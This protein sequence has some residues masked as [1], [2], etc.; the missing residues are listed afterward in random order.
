MIVKMKKYTVLLHKSLR[1]SFLERLQELG[2]MDVTVAD[3]E[4]DDA[5]RELLSQIERRRRAAERF[6]EMKLSPEELAL[7][8]PYA[9][10]REA[11][12]AYAHASSEIDSIE[13]SLA[14]LDKEMDE[15]KL[16][17][18]IPIDQMNALLARGVQIYFYS[19]SSSEFK[20]KYDQWAEQYALEEISDVNGTTCFVIF[21]TEE[22]EPQIDA[23]Q[24]KRPTATLQQREQ[25][26]EKLSAQLEEWQKVVVRAA[27]SAK[28]IE[29]DAD[30]LKDRLQ[31]SQVASTSGSEIEGHVVVLRG[32]APVD[33][34]AAVDAMLD[35]SPETIYIKE[36]PAPD[37]ETP[38]L[39]RNNRFAR[40]FELI[41]SFYSL[42]KYG[43]M[44]L[45]PYFAPFY[46]IFFGFCMGDAGYGVL[47][48]LIGLF[49]KWKKGNGMLGGVSTLTILLGISTIIFGLLTGS[50]F[51]IQLANFALLEPY[52]EKFLNTNNLF[53]LAFALGIVQILFG[54]TLNVINTTR[55]QGFIYS[56]GTLGWLI[57]LLA[58][59][60]AAAVPALGGY[61]FSFHSVAYYVLLGIGGVL[62]LFLNNPKRNPI[63]NFGAG[64]WNTYNNVT[65]LLGDVLSYVRLF[66]LCLS[67]GALSLVFN[68][69]AVSLA[70]D[71]P[72]VKQIFT[73][74]ILLFGHAMNI[75]M[76]AIGAFVHPMRLTFVEFYKNAGFEA[77]MR[78]FTPFS[79]HK[80]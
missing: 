17:G 50:C 79:K 58:S 37:D 65:G 1:D 9:N 44:D 43:T 7:Q 18:A 67:G 77:S 64:L 48:L 56:F 75:F 80:A 21:S 23:Q 2:M 63:I 16:W 39:L 68:D 78:E 42:P 6:A 15:L 30:E 11:F 35:D 24:H 31:L 60:A 41:G 62:M 19:V 27:A 55:S 13:S 12:E 52:K 49:L 34:V 14:R 22:Q 3:W 45:T 40:Q 72:V 59:I 51:G 8:Q 33:S 66:A 38:V 76:S 69:L 73:M 29:A 57:I 61:W 5:E 53:Y 20:T 47:F 26:H 28:M 54:M 71:I 70:P 4:P 36:N 25:Q 32:W 10:G 46:M 74:I